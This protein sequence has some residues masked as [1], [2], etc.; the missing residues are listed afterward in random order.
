MKIDTF[1]TQGDSHYICEDYIVSDESKIVLSDGCSSSIDTDVGARIL[2]RT[3]LEGFTP[4][5]F[6]AFMNDL[7]TRYFTLISGKR[8]GANS[9]DATVGFVTEEG[10]VT[11][12][13]DGVIFWK[14][15]DG[16][17]GFTEIEY[18][19]GAPFYLSY[20]LSEDREYEYKKAFG[21]TKFIK[22]SS[23]FTSVVSD[24]GGYT[25][26]FDISEMELIGI[27]SDGLTSF[28]NTPSEERA[29]GEIINEI[30][31]FKSYNGEFLKR[32][33]GKI[34]KTYRKKGITHYDDLSIG[35]IV[36]KED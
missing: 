6:S 11:F 8:N 21:N 25:C 15:K 16:E 29:L 22:H 7:Y 5:Y 1:L 31:D 17:V 12:Y 10:L 30:C 36:F 33:M 14:T 35:V 27:A 3:F 26:S 20:F 19:S 28:L 2:C 18:P 23:G 32:R 4:K 13:G 24:G 9:L 34:L